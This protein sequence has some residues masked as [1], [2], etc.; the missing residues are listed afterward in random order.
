MA[1]IFIQ[2]AFLC[3]SEGVCYPV[4]SRTRPRRHLII[5]LI[6]VVIFAVGFNL[7]KAF[8]TKVVQV[9]VRNPLCYTIW[10]LYCSER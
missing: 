2:K 8:E 3:I 7:P 1:P 6:P 5:Y 10:A 4:Q 9:Q